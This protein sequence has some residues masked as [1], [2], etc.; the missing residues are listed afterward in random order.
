MLWRSEWQAATEA[1]ASRKHDGTTTFK[2]IGV[3]GALNRDVERVFGPPR[4]EPHLG[5]RKPA[6]SG[7]PVSLA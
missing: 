4:K 1:V 6:V 5:H 2:R 7:W 3:M